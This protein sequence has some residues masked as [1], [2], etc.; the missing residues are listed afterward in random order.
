M[1]KKIA[2]VTYFT[3]SRYDELITNVENSFLKFNGDVCDFY[4]IDYNN[5]DDYNQSLVYYDFA[6]ETFLMQYIYAY[7]IMRKYEYE[8]IIILGTDTI[9]CSRMDDNKTPIL[10]TLNYYIQESGVGWTSSTETITL[11]DGSQY[12]EH[13]N[14]NADVC[15]FNSHEALKDVIQLSIENYD[16]FSIQGGLN[17]MIHTEKHYEYK[18]VD[19][20]YVLSDISYNCRSKGVPRTDM[21]DGGIIK[22]CWPQNVHGF[23]YN[24]LK[25]R[26]LI[27]GEPSPIKNWY[28][29]DEKLFTKDHKQIKCFHF[30]EGIGGRPIEDFNKLINDF[31]TNWFNNETIKF[32]RDVCNCTTFFK[33]IKI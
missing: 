27:D 18:I 32:F 24:W 2:C 17:R 15:C 10:A 30:V 20:P 21:I 13:L 23:D 19:S 28:V 8:K 29:K 7:E 31:K 5:R 11:P 6:E 22:N 14:V 12:L 16:H 25:E 3:D 1:N 26:N 4:R 33:E 9:V